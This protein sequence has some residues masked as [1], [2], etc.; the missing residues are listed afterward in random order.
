MNCRRESM[1]T[2]KV[3]PSQ[4]TPPAGIWARATSLGSGAGSAK[5]LLARARRT[6]DWKSMIVVMVVECE[7]GKLD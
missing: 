7:A 3:A 5:V 1:R 2:L 4:L 6:V